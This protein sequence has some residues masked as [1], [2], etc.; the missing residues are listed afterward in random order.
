[1]LLKKEITDKQ[2]HILKKAEELFATNGF[3][4]TSVRDIARAAKVNLAMISYYFGSK[5]KL[6]ETL[7]IDRMKQGLER[8][9]SLLANPAI[10]PIQKLE[11]MVDS[12]CEK[13][14]HNNNFFRSSMVAQLTKH[15]KVV[16]NLIFKSREQYAKAFEQILKEGIENGQ[17]KYSYDFVFFLNIFNGILMQSIVNKDFY[18]EYRKDGVAGEDFDKD[19]YENIAAQL[20]IVLKRILGYEEKK[21]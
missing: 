12:Y 14:S 9:E 3:N 11:I 18:K 15:N 4:A 8:T 19:Y 13:I 2:A 20:K 16:L 21:K 1:M 6:I 10:T 7:F 17:F 5:E